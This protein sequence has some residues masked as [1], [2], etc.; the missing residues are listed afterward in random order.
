MLEGN[1]HDAEKTCL[2]NSSN[3]LM[4]QILYHRAIKKSNGYVG[5][6]ITFLFDFRELG[7]W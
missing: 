3:V 4:D 6:I 1:W 7:L 2:D 5:N